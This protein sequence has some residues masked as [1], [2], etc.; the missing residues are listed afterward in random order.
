MDG[1]RVARP[2]STVTYPRAG[3]RLAPEL[4]RE[5]LGAGL[6]PPVAS[7]DRGSFVRL[8]DLDESVW[9][10]LTPA[11]CRQ[12]GA[13]IVRQVSVALRGRLSIGE[14]HLPR[15]PPDVGLA[16]LA[17]EARTRHCLAAA[18]LLERP[19]ELAEWT[20]ERL[21][22]LR[23]F[24]AKSLVDLLVAVE[25]TR[26]HPTAVK[27]A[28]RVEVPLRRAA[29]PGN[30]YPRPLQRLAPKTLRSLLT[31]PIPPGLVRGTRLE[32]LCLCD[33]DQRVW[34]ELS[35]P[36]I[37]RLAGHVVQ[38][39]S[40][41]GWPRAITQ[42]RLP[43]PAPGLPLE[44]LHLET[45]TAN[46]LRQAGLGGTCEKL[47]GQSIG[48]LLQIKA[49]GAKC[50]V[51]LLC[52]W[53]SAREQA[54]RLD[55]ALT[56]AARALTA[57]PRAAGIAATDPRLGADLRALAADAPSLGPAV[58]QIVGRRFDPPHPA[59]LTEQLQAVAQKIAA[60]DRLRLED[61]LLEIFCPLGSARDRQIIGEY[62]GWDGRPERT[63]EELGRQYGLSRERIR[64][65]CVRG[66]KR[67]RGVGVFAPVLDRVLEQIAAGLPQAI[68]AVQERLRQS[69][70]VQG[71]LSLRNVLHAARLLHRPIVVALVDVQGQPL[72][73]RPEDAGQPPQI[74]RA[75]A[76]AAYGFGLATVAQLR[77]E[78]GGSAG[79]AVTRA[80]IQHTLPLLPG[81][82]W[83]D[84]RQQWF[85]MECPLQSGLA[86][87]ISKVLAVAPRITLRELRAAL[88]RDQR[89]AQRL[90]PP[91]VLREFCRTLPRVRVETGRIAAESTLDRR[92]ALSRAEAVMADVLGRHKSV[93]ER[94]EF[95]EACLR[96][97]INRFTFNATVM[98]SPIIARFG[99]SLYGLVGTRLS[100]NAL[101]AL[102]RSRPQGSRRVLAGS[103]Q[104]DDGRLLLA[105]RLS[106]AAIAGGV[107]TVP[108]HL[109]G[110]ITGRF[111]L[112]TASGASVGT[113]V[114]KNGCAWGLGP[115]LRGQA[116]RPGDHLL[117]LLDA[118]R[119]EARIRLGDAGMLQE[120]GIAD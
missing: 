23:G 45:R 116:A 66:V 44:A 77:S 72:A 15:L 33:L 52:A 120:R 67:E 13:E 46:C 82:R 35:A 109:R 55:P 41:S 25:H 111:S 105:Y 43:R 58:A 7:G 4:L 112:L 2:L 103:G 87:Q 86:M 14:R 34:T 119:H 85:R 19:Q 61:E 106:K 80:M 5:I 98:N 10:R 9:R 113:M 91:R 84:P 63:L 71:D 117:M 50:L 56:A 89:R 36:T 12:C 30:H 31:E 18:G 26:A 47:A 76:R 75:A 40:A 79:R 81:F 115:A 99:R 48:D 101:A 62:Y 21:L 68:P 90:P 22:A 51:D 59:A 70:L 100:R 29:G 118:A 88:A 114:S 1:S 110:R 102:P 54:G 60:L 24:G 96:R 27:R 57:D 28:A 78:V 37:A 42:Q 83:L 95:E 65:V 38:R 64:Q 73:V 107:L 69:G 17:L 39:V 74:A 104:T 11:E 32:G 93:L 6:P 49:F 16:E 97:G 20:I 94:G 8:A 53:E 3:Q 108:A 92:P